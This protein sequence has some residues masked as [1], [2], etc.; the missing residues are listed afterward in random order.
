M[1]KA[2]YAFSGDPITYG[3]IDIV[4]RAAAK[5]EHLTVGVGTNAEKIGKQLFTPEERRELA[6]RALRKLPNVDVVTFEGSL[7]H[8]AYEQGIDTIV[9]GTRNSEDA[10]KETELYH[11]VQSQGLPI[12]FMFLPAEEKYLHISSSAVKEWQRIHGEI[13]DYVP[14][15]VKQAL[16]ERISGQYMLG[17]TGTIGSGKSYVTKQLVEAGSRLGIP[18]HEMDLDRM[19]HEIL[20][21]ASAPLYSRTRQQIADAFGVPLGPDGIDRAALGNIVFSDPK[22]REELNAIM[23]NPMRTYFRRALNGKK[24]IIALNAALIAELGWS[25]VVNNNI[26]VIDVD[27]KTQADRLR[28]RGHADAEIERRVNSQ[29]TTEQKI[30]IIESEIERYDSGR[31]WKLDNSG[32]AIDFD[33]LLKGIAGD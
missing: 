10:R 24:G 4:K 11:L 27:K 8:Y 29:Y 5:V 13:A 26:L 6:A 12:D 21:T 33:A 20:S 32:A 1:A 18:V 30:S 2:I 23:A 28:T 14:L 19:G 7:V 9:R 25:N 3:H 17:I 16:E 22:R 15:H 31:I